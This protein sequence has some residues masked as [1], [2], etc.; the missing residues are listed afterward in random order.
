MRHW[1]PSSIEANPAI[2]VE[3]R[4]TPWANWYQTFTTAIG[5]GTAPDVSTGAAY[6]AVQFYDQGA[7][8]AVND[9]VAALESSGALADFLPSTI[10]RLRYDD[11]DVAVPWDDQHPRPLL[12]KGSV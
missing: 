2:Q 11:H 6:Q 4:S 9:V 1:F 12:P 8:A 3:Y 10:E 7:V 5:A